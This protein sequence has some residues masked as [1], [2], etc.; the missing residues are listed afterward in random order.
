MKIMSLI[1]TVI[2]ILQLAA[3]SN[4][5]TTIHVTLSDYSYTPSTF[6][7]PA[8]KEITLNLINKGF[9][10]HA[11]IIFKLGAD[12]GEKF[13]PEDGENIYWKVEVSP[14]KSA[15]A[16]IHGACQIRQLLRDLWTWWA[17]RSGYGWYLD[18]GRFVTGWETI[19]IGNRAISLTVRH[20]G[21]DRHD[22]SL[23]RRGVANLLNAIHSLN[24]ITHKIHQPGGDPSEFKSILEEKFK[25]FPKKT[26]LEGFQWYGI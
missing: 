21:T 1:L 19:P 6:T 4:L 12:A 2:L 22:I 18:C 13:G 3:C 11:F 20:R 7:V 9:V 24:C 23:W 14:G 17:S 15:T 8:G 26:K 10:S 16:K 5:P 25:L